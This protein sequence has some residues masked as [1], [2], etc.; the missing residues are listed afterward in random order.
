M[1]T[2]PHIE[3]VVVLMLE[4]RSLDNV[5]GWLHRDQ[6]GYR[7]PVNIWPPRDLPQYFDGIPDGAS[8]RKGVEIYQPTRGHAS[9]GQQQWRVPRWDPKE[10]I[11]DVHRQMY[12]RADGITFDIDWGSNI[13]MGGF[14]QD[15]PAGIE[16]G[17]G[18]VMGAYTRHELPV[19]YSLAEQFAVSDRWFASVPSETDPNRA[20]S[21][22]GTAQ[23]HEYAWQ[24]KKFTNPTLFG[25]LNA[26]N[27]RSSG[28]KSWGIFF[29]DS[30][31]SSMAGSDAICY[32]QGRFTQIE[33]ELLQ[34]NGDGEITPYDDFLK[35]LR[36]GGPIPQFC[37]VE[38]SWGWGLGFTDGS[39]FHGFQGTDY[40]PPAWIG[41]A[42]WH[43][44]E[45]YEALRNSAQWESMLFVVVF[46]EHGGTWDHTAP[47]RCAKPDDTLA[48]FPVPFSYERMGP[49]VPALL[50]SPF[51]APKTV[52]RA[53]PNSRAAFDH[54][55]LLKTVLQW[56]GTD[57]RY[58]DAMG[59]RVRH[60]PTFDGVLATTF[61]Q[62][63][64]PMYVE[65]PSGYQHQCPLGPRHL[66]FDHAELL[67]RD[68]H[69][70]A[71]AASPT[72]EDYLQQVASL[73]KLRFE[74][75]GR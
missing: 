39:D 6:A 28:G 65:V 75:T 71:V 9:L 51:V 4:N 72:V 7:Q 46:D 53:P 63:T 18:E 8:N 45:L 74:R 73:A 62:P 44:N 52:F 49:R 54:T 2:M 19:L 69:H 66:L 32:T 17:V 41:P 57:Q 13:P 12:A 67:T 48:T 40:H 56:A 31:F 38:P 60:A 58:I 37:Y 35:R 27:A 11:L 36:T 34:S 3:T 16:S 15:F 14:A 10:G 23:G 64:Y 26:A 20:F 50:V 70:L 5:L 24:S 68:D 22:M 29:R 1:S 42:E 25:G 21:L 33:R 30:G 59:E 47:P 43:L 61:Q 55:S